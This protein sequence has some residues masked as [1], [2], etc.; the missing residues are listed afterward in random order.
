MNKGQRLK[1]T[2]ECPCDQSMFE[3]KFR[4]SAPPTGETA[5]DWAEQEYLRRYDRCTA[6]GH[7]FGVHKLD[8][9]DLY[10][11]DYVQ[12]TYGSRMA[13]TFD[14]IVSL[15]K[16]RSDNSGRCQRLVEFAAKKLTA[17]SSPTLLDIG[18]GLGVFPYA[19]KEAGWTCT[20]LDPDPNACAHIAE[21]A[22]VSTINTDFL[23]ADMSSLG[24]Y[25]VVT[26]NKVIEHV[27]DP[28]SMLRRAASVTTANGFVYVE[29]PDG[30]GAAPYGEGREEFFVEHHH[31]FSAASLC[32]T[33]ERCGLQVA[34]LDR[35]VEPS[36]K[37]TLSCFAVHRV[38]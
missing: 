27:E 9:Q 38:S 11:G 20:A 8:L 30:D 23:T 22:G 6:C 21:R 13:A 37:F 28:C 36:G 17:V 33:V 2:I 25:D 31:V 29:V 26:L 14:K 35:L 7:W 4:Y 32:T 24:T 5:F 3:T 12:S 1:P 10:S 16:D 34:H 19:M 18:S 15:P